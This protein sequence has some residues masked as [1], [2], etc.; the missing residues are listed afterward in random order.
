M[1]WVPIP[2]EKNKNGSGKSRILRT[3]QRILMV[4]WFCTHCT[5]GFITIFHQHLGYIFLE[6]FQASEQANPGRCPDF[7]LKMWDF[8]LCFQIGKQRRNQT[9]SELNC[10]CTNKPL[11]GSSFFRLPILRTQEGMIRY[12]P[13]FSGDEWDEYF[14]KFLEGSSIE[15]IILP[16]NHGIS[17]HWWFGDPRPLRTTHPNP[18]E[19]LG[20]ES[21]ES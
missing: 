5:M 12:I 17:S 16:K 6:L 8:Q 14:I 13:M 3:K 9:H 10:R 7:L 1:F 2:S 19:N 18:S 4:R 11:Y 15:M 21:W 20:Q